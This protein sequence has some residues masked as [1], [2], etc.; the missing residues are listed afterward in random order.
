MKWIKAIYITKFNEP[1]NALG[2]GAP[3]AGCQ[4]M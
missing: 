1:L 3:G 2:I 4:T